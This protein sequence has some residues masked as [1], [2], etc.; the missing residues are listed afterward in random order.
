MVL[1]MEQEFYIL[2]RGSQQKSQHPQAARRRVTA[3]PIPLTVTHL[4]QQGHTC[5][6][7]TTPRPSRPHLLVVLLPPHLLWRTER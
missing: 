6:N 1:E 3:E 2:I 7:K 5:S 4:L